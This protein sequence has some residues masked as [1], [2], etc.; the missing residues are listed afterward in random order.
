M[1][2][3]RFSALLEAYG[4]DPRRWPAD[5]RAAAGR[6]ATGQK[7]EQA[8]AAALDRLLDAATVPAPAPGLRTRVLA[9][10]TSASADEGRR[11]GRGI[12]GLFSGW[13]LAALG[14]AAAC[15]AALP[16]VLYPSLAERREDL[17]A[18]AEVQALYGT[19]LPENDW[20]PVL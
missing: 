11:S 1:T 10:M 13:R 2:P 16:M 17:A 18:L 9:A 14:A 15:G 8:E 7:A 3:E 4:A 6:F 19:A 12:A 20:E 5:E